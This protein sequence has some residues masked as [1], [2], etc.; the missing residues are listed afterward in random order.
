M[1]ERKHP[2]S[3]D[4]TA[5]AMLFERLAI[6]INERADGDRVGFTTILSELKTQVLGEGELKKPAGDFTFEEVVETFELKY[7]SVA[8]ATSASQFFWA[9]EDLLQSPFPMTPCLGNH[10][11]SLNH[12]L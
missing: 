12:A 11:I 8:S 9:I 5:I 10:F 7:D 2:G 1:A 6:L 4:E 3:I